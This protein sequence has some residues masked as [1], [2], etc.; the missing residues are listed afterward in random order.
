MQTARIK[1]PSCQVQLDVRNSKNEAV[2]TINCP[3]CGATISVRFQQKQQ[4]PAQPAEGETIVGPIGPQKPTTGGQQLRA[5]LSHQG[6]I[7]PLAP[8][9][10]TIGRRAQTSSAKVQIDVP[11]DKYFSRTH[12]VITVTPLPGGGVKASIAEAN[13]KNPIFVK[14]QPL[15]KGDQLIL[16]NGDEL[17]MGNTTLIYTILK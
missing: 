12:A 1:C 15:L 17:R 10:N 16:S 4:M 5:A 14:G 6:H 7:Y 9:P 3:K 11:G 8:G 13:N 2:K